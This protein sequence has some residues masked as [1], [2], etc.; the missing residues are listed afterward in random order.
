[1]VKA[2]EKCCQICGEVKPKEEFVRYK[3]YMKDVP[4][5]SCWCKDC[6]R[7]HYYMKKDERKEKELAKV[8]SFF[9]AFD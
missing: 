8:G 5:K 2:K 6:L 1:M 4:K 7:M 9:V 3:C